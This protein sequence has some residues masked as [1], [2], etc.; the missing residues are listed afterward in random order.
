MGY[1]LCQNIET[2]LISAYILCFIYPDLLQNKATTRI[3]FYKRLLRD[4]EREFFDQKQQLNL[5]VDS[6]QGTYK[7][8]FNLVKCQIW[9]FS[10]LCDNIIMF[11]NIM[12]YCYFTYI[13]CR[14]I[15]ISKWSNPRF[16][17]PHFFSIFFL[18][19]DK[20]NQE[21]EEK[22]AMLLQHQE[23]EESMKQE[24]SVVCMQLSTYVHTRIRTNT[25][26]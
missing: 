3:D 14:C 12:L 25:Y 8:T 19:S 24:H 16:F 4:T 11:Y 20:L 1:E 21:I 7:S 9:Y 26:T 5:Q 13:L 10:V 17:C 15:S 6:L 18:I 22:R 2:L 23:D